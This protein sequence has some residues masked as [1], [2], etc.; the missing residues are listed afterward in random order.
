MRYQLRLPGL[1]IAAVLLVTACNS[2]TS[3]TTAPASAAAPS[4]AAPS[5]AAPSDSAG[6]PASAGADVMGVD[7]G[8]QLTHVDAAPPPRRTPSRSST[9]T[10]RPTRTR[11]T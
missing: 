4:A 2:S 10:T 6:A 5:A 7:D 11:S 3:P 9:R 8:T 1:A